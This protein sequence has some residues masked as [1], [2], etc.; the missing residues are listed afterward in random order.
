MN[1]KPS[2]TQT[3]VLFYLLIYLAK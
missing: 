3:R 1:F 2:T